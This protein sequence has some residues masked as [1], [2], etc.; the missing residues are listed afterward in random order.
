MFKY[1]MII[2]THGKNNF[3]DLGIASLKGGLR[4]VVWTDTF[5]TF[6]VVGGLIGIIIMGCNKVGG[7][8]EIWRISQEGQRIQFFE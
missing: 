2:F 1:F 6:I 7:M 4:A 8:A 5:Q 3:D